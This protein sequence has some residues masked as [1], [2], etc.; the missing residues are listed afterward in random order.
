MW[1]RSSILVIINMGVEM[2]YILNQRLEAQKIDE[3]KAVIVLRD[4][5]EQIFNDKM[6]QQ[7]LCSETRPTPQFALQLF[8]R[9]VHCS[10]MK[11]N[12]TSMQ[13]L[14]DLMLMGL[15]H[16]VVTLKRPR[17]LLDI[18]YNHLDTMVAMLSHSQEL[19]TVCQGQVRQLLKTKELIRQ[20]FNPSSDYTFT[21][22]RA[23]I[24][25]FLQNKQVKVSIF[26]QSSIQDNS[27]QFILYTGTTTT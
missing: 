20:T 21:L 14:F 7:I 15:K 13:K 4:I 27:G 10:I 16:Q 6:M 5:S 24:L 17:E 9:I 8:H 18:T 1:Q 3:K 26:L 22:L 23:D 12:E 2:L 11:L 25:S 19:K